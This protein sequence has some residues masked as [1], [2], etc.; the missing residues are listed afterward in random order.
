LF[1]GYLV[2]VL[3]VAVFLG[4]TSG[5]PLKTLDW[6]LLGVGLTQI[7]SIEA[8]IVVGFFFVM[9]KRATTLDL[10]PVK[11]NFVQFLVVL[12]VLAFASVL[13][14]AVQSGLLV[15]PDMQV[16]GA[17]SHGNSLQWYVDDS[18]PELPQPT[19]VSAP[20]WVYRVLMLAW[21]L[22]LARKLLTWA[23][24][25]FRAFAAGGLWKKRV[26]A[27]PPAAPGP[28]APIPG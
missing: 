25:A 9:A 28:A 23:P 11:H 10:T 7:S 4:R 13:F 1:W 19:L 21:S 5:P 22:W 18:G 2:L 16:M 12:W 6:L 27:K 15:Q 17:G 3:L 20:M 24:W 26:K 8:L 14:D